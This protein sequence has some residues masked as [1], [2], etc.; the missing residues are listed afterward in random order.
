MK[1]ARAILSLALAI[2]FTAF[3]LWIGFVGL[4]PLPALG[5]TFNP[6]TGVWTMAGD[7]KRPTSET[8]TVPGL[9][10]P[11]TVLFNRQG[12]AYIRAQTDHDLFLAIGYLQAKN[13]LFQMDLMRRQGEGLLSQVIGPAALSSDRF[14]LE[15]G[16]LRTA[17]ANWQSLPRSSAAHRALVA[18]AAGVNDVIRQDEAQGTLPA[19][20]KLL[21]YR[22]A[23]WTPIDSLIVQGDMTQSL[24]YTTAPVEYELLTHALGYH[25]TM[26]WFPL[27]ALNVQHPYDLGPYRKL[28]LT[29][30]TSQAAVQTG[31]D[32]VGGVPTGSLNP[33]QA[34]SAGAVG[35]TI[36][37]TTI[38]NPRDSYRTMCHRCFNL[39]S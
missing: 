19:M 23:P 4:G 35:G 38:N 9:R 7:A 2:V 6:A 26:A 3:V 24:D 39:S 30:M 36:R 18:Y 33:R 37:V 12:T 10:R 29:R 5:A 25:R 28:P 32:L 21:N 11:V 15:L 16:L 20:F 13:R 14:E 22:P 34:S 8:L 27:K 17:R 31:Y 1:R